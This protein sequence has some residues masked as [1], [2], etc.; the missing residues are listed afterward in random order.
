MDQPPA[1]KFTRNV[2]NMI[3]YDA[4]LIIF[5]FN[6]NLGRKNLNTLAWE[7]DYYEE[8]PIIP[9]D[10]IK[11]ING[12]NYSL[13]VIITNRNNLCMLFMKNENTW[14]NYN[15]HYNVEN[16]SDYISVIGS[17]DKLLEYKDKFV[18]KH[19]NLYIYKFMH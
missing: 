3:I 15:S 5:D 6:R 8:L 1:I 11:D 2:D 7:A 14:L 4:E 10:N 12:N 17:Y 18:S 16:T 13:E 9:N 19:G